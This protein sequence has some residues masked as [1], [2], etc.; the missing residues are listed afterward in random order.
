MAKKPLE[1]KLEM[2]LQESQEEAFPSAVEEVNSIIL[3][4]EA[5]RTGVKRQYML[6]IGALAN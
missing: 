5:S 6:M 4:G 3:G 2:K 1:S